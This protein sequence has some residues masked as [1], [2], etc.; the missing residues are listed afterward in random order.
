MALPFSFLSKT[1]GEKARSMMDIAPTCLRF[2]VTYTNIAPEQDY[3]DQ[4][5]PRE[6]ISFL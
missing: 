1:C 4:L 5:A 6:T 3:E 2:F